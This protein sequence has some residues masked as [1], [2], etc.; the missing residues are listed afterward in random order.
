MLDAGPILAA[1]TVSDMI[2]FGY[3]LA[4]GAFLLGLG[5]SASLRKRERA[6]EDESG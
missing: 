5:L 6:T 3:V 2:T 1:S 4:V